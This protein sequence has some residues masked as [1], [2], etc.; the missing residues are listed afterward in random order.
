MFCPKCGTEYPDTEGECPACGAR[1]RRR[2]TSV[3][4]EHTAFERAVRALRQIVPKVVLLTMPLVIIALGIKAFVD[5]MPGMI[6]VVKPLDNPLPSL[7]AI[8][9][10]ACLVPSLIPALSIIPLM[11]GLIRGRYVW[12]DIH[13]ARATFLVSIV[14]CLAILAGTRILELGVIDAIPTSI[15]QVF[16]ESYG[17]ASFLGIVLS[18]LQMVLFVVYRK[19]FR[20][21]NE[22]LNRQERLVLEA[23]G[24][25]CCKQCGAANSSNVEFCKECGHPL[26]T[27]HGSRSNKPGKRWWFIILLSLLLIAAVIFVFNRAKDVLILQHV[28]NS[29]NYV[30]K[31]SVIER[32]D[33]GT[34]TDVPDVATVTAELEK[35][36]F[37]GYTITASYSQDGIIRDTEEIDP[38]S[39]EKCPL[40]NVFYETPKGMWWVIYVCNGKYMANPLFMYDATLVQNLVV[41]DEYVTSYSSNSNEFIVSVPDDSELLMRRVDRIDAETLGA[42][43]EAGVEAL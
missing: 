5:D 28:D 38:T 42:L 10:C 20:D 26:K 1:S 36:G 29:G 9:F 33:A 2:K 15:V 22:L 11:R 27:I 41:E 6:Q 16:Y 14:G 39:G 12:K 31:E 17:I 24:R 30:F 13:I 18:L 35:R 3:L 21:D 23:S 37:S 19:W 25:V 32:I 8:A 34:S 40:Y 4:L 7:T 43:D